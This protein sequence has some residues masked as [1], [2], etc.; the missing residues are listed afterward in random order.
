MIATVGVV[1][2]LVFLEIA[3]SL[4]NALVLAVL[5]QP[6]GRELRQKALVYGMW[7]AFIF[8]IL[9]VGLLTFL[10]HMT[11]IKVIAACYLLYL[12][13]KHFAVED[14]DDA[15]TNSA[16]NFWKTILLVELTDIAFSA[17]SIFAGVG[18]SSHAWIIALGGIFGIVVM[19]FVAFQATLLI[20]KFP[21]LQDVAYV[22]VGVIG[23]KLLVFG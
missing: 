5:V 23:L 20:D 9:A 10:M 8:R 15:V 3:L 17:D 6:L 2:L 18:V 7:G 11:F 4:D 12:C 19:R 16:T 13:V 21:R 1:L 22:L 14:A